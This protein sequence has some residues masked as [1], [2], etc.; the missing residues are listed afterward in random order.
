MHARNYIKTKYSD[1]FFRFIINI[2]EDP[3]II[4]R[5]MNP[6]NQFSTNYRAESDL[7]SREPEARPTRSGGNRGMD[8]EERRSEYK[9]STFHKRNDRA[10][11][12]WSDLNCHV[13]PPGVQPQRQPAA[14]AVKDEQHMPLINASNDGL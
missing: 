8:R 11:L 5:K 2:K 6:T 9:K 3:Y 14:K 4:K 12:T 1:L 7:E 13:P 10:L